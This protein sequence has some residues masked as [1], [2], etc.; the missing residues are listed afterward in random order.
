VTVQQIRFCLE[1]ERQGSITRA[2]EQLFLSQP[3]LS[4]ALRDLEQ[5]LG[6]PLFERTPSGMIPTPQGNRFLREGAEIVAAMDRLTLGFQAPKEF[7]LSM[8][9]VHCHKLP[10][11]L[12]AACAGLEKQP[13]YMDV[14]VMSNREVLERVNEGQAHMGLIR[15]PISRGEEIAARLRRMGL[16]YRRWLAVK[17][18]LSLSKPQWG[19]TDLSDVAK[20]ITTGKRIRRQ[21]EEEWSFLPH[22][23]G[24]WVD[25]YGEDAY[26][27][28]RATPQSYY[29]DL[30][31]LAEEMP[32]KIMQI[33]LKEAEISLHWIIW[34]TDSPHEALIHAWDSEY[35]HT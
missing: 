12:Q 20:I 5:E 26:T 10:S 27:W 1:I 7:T 34:P 13:S 30:P 24:H 18:C 11:A 15:Y 2:A 3:N 22:L 35:D 8:A 21:E 4:R 28:L 29:V 17:P 16:Q 32:S 25:L 19:E 14:R 23:E 6:I 33:P 31:R 9:T